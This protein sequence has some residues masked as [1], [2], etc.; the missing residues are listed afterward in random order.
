MK[1]K[2]MLKFD[3]APT[4]FR[5]QIHTYTHIYKEKKDSEVAVA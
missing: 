2:N 4:S 1:K 5:T 3:I